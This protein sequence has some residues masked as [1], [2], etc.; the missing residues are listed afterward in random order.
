MIFDYLDTNF[1]D[2]F[3]QALYLCGNKKLV[4]IFISY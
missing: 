1:T 2:I 4:S 3:I